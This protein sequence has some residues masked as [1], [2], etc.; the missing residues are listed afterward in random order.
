MVHAARPEIKWMP[1]AGSERQD[2]S[3][4]CFL[5]KQQCAQVAP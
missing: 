2:E 5:W 4:R 3:R 1:I